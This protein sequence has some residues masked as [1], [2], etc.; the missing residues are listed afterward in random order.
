[1]NTSKKGL[2]WLLFKAFGPL[3]LKNL[4]NHIDKILEEYSDITVYPVGEFSFSV[5]KPEEDLSELIVFPTAQE[6][7]AFIRGIKYGVSIVGE[8]VQV[9]TREQF[10]EIN[11]MDKYST[12]KDKKTRLN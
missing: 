5:K 10:N 11:N 2:R 12:H 3:E 7:A 1:M 8:S 9:L 6:R 4:V